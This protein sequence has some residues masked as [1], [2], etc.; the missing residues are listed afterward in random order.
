MFDGVESVEVKEGFTISLVYFY[1]FFFF[2]RVGKCYT[3]SWVLS[4][5]F[6][7]GNLYSVGLSHECVCK[8]AWKV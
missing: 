1:F 7:Y 2:L 8:T 5:I 6:P 4:F 3:H